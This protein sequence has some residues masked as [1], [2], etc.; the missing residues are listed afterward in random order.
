VGGAVDLIEDGQSGRLVAPGQ[1]S[2]LQ[3]A[4]AS[5]LA[6]RRCARGSARV[7]ASA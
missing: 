2:A 4:L 1:P 3:D 5:V 7:R 6:D